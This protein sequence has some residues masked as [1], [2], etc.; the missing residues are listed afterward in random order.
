MADLRTLYFA[1]CVSRLDVAEQRLLASPCLKTGR[2]PLAAFWNA[3][4]AAWAMNQLLDAPPRARWVVW[5]HQDV[6]LPE[7]WDTLFMQRLAEAE[8]RWPRLAV[9]GV[10]GL[11]GHGA[12][13]ERGGH[14]LDRGGDLREAAALPM[15]A[16]SLDELLFAVRAQVPFRLDEA[17]GFDFYATDTVLQAQQHGL[18]A[19]V[20][21]AFCEHWSDTP[22]RGPVA[23]GLV[24][25]I[26]A[27]A[28]VFER[29][30]A[31]RLP[32]TTPCFHIDQPGDTLAFMQWAQ[33]Q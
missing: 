8:H 20:V 18:E 28:E 14:V 6:Y 3:P 2:H 24:R 29:K 13:A 25:R 12:Q 27:S 23:Q 15:L 5:L 26:A 11:R 1:S 16:D 19:A 4:S 30:W 22:S 10:Y 9:A 7:G 33:T 32:I 21:D 31:H 17:L